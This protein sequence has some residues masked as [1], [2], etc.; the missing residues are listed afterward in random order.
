MKAAAAPE[1]RNFAAV[2]GE[3]GLEAWLRTCAAALAARL[4]AKRPPGAEADDGGKSGAEAEWGGGDGGE[5]GEASF[6]LALEEHLL[7]E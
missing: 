5:P 3:L 6:D 4:P 2:G 7:S 1:V